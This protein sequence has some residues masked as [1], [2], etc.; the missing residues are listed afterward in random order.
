MA[1]LVFTEMTEVRLATL[2]ALSL[3]Q[4]HLVQFT[5][6]RSR[7]ISDPCTVS[8]AAPV[9]IRDLTAG[10]YTAPVRRVSRRVPG[11]CPI[12]LALGGASAVVCAIG[13]CRKQDEDL[14]TDLWA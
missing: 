1:L 4:R 10:P 8:G 3:L 14:D 7:A 6:D 12:L 13:T 2:R 9:F 11:S 5:G